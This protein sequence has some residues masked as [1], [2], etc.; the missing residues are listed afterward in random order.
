MG[1][2]IM[3]KRKRKEMRMSDSTQLFITEFMTEKEKFPEIKLELAE[4]EEEKDK[5]QS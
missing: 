2:D 3:S 4:K 5:N 1:G